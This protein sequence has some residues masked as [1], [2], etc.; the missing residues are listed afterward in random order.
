VHERR[1]QQEKEKRESNKNKKKRNSTTSCSHALRTVEVCWLLLASNLF[2][3]VLRRHCVRCELCV[4]HRS[5]KHCP[6]HLRLGLRRGVDATREDPSSDGMLIP[7]CLFF[8]Q[9]FSFHG[10]AGCLG[11]A[12]SQ[13]IFS[14]G[15]DMCSSSK[16]ASLSA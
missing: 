6:G 1:N 10:A 8:W 3:L 12:S 13:A 2:A 11:E 5:E 14:R 9:A 15:V 4:E 7:C 16:K